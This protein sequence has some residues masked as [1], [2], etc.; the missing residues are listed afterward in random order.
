MLLLINIHHC[1]GEQIN[2]VESEKQQF[3]MLVKSYIYICKMKTSV[4]CLSLC[5]HCLEQTLAIERGK[6]KQVIANL[7]T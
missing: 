7:V 6:G 4:K 1:A 5:G 3:Q 2:R